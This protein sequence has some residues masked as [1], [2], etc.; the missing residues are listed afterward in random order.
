LSSG[1]RRLGV[2]FR[3]R[4]Y[5]AAPEDVSAIITAT[6]SREPVLA[7]WRE[8]QTVDPQ[9]LLLAFAGLV[10]VAG[11]PPLPDIVSALWEG[12]TKLFVEIQPSLERV[13]DRVAETLA[14]LLAAADGEPA[15]MH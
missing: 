11:G 13:A 4:L 2:V 6:L 8:R 9:L 15:T 5:V 1:D 14:G 7:A 3:G 10:H 12:E